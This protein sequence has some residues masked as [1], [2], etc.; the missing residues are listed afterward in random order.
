MNIPDDTI[1]EKCAIFCIDPIGR[2]STLDKIKKKK[3]FCWVLLS[4]L[5]S[6]LVKRAQAC[7]EQITI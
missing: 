6:Y 5:K 1:V 4:G 3:L 7:E 2:E